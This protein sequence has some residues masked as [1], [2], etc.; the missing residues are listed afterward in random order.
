MSEPER[1]ALVNLR[2]IADY[3]DPPAQVT[4]LVTQHAKRQ[5]GRW[6]HEVYGSN[7]GG[8]A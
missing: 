8:D 5:V 3:L 1:P 6:L 2:A 4:V 7:I